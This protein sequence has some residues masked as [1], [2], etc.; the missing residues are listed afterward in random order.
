MMH[1]AAFFSAILAAPHDDEP[2][3]AYAHWLDERDDPLGEFIRLQCQLERLALAHPLRL[4]LESRE[5]ELLGDHQTRWLG[6]IIPTVHWAVFRRGFVEEVSLSTV[7]FLRHAGDLFELAPI[8]QVHL[9]AVRDRMADLAG[10][11]HLARLTYLDLSN[12]HL[13]D[14]GIRILAQSSYVS[15]LEGLNLSSTC[16]GDVGLRALVGSPYLT[17]LR[18]LFLCDNRITPVGLRALADSPLMAQLETLSLRSNACSAAGR[19]LVPP[20]LAVALHL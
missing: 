10:C 12:N 17:N 11:R 4:D 15:G 13:R 8:H 7:N 16:L 9:N 2:R 1:P 18:E 14:H 5:R 3:L 6:S 20:D 19:D